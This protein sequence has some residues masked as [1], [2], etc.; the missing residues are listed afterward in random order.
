VR[1]LRA[2]VASLLGVVFV[3]GSALIGSTTATAAEPQAYVAITFTGMS[4]SLPTRSGDVTLEGKVTNTSKVS[5]SNLQAV[6]WRSLD[7]IQD[8]EGMQAALA[9]DAND[10]LGARKADAYQNIP[11]ETDRTLAPK[12]STT[13]KL[14]VRVSALQLPS[15]DAIYLLGIH[16]RGRLEPN[17]PDVTLGRG[18][19]FA[20]I[21]ATAPESAAQLSTLVMLESRPSLIRKGV[22]ADDHLATEIGPDGRLTALLEAA[23]AD[24]S[25]FAVDPAL[26]EELQTMRS[27]YQV[28]QPDGDTVPGT[29]QSAAGRWLADYTRMAARQDGYRLL[30]AHPDVT[31]LVHAGMTSVI[32]G[33]QVA[34]KAVTTT[35]AL[36]LLAVPVSGLLDQATAESLAELDPK[37]I[38]VD[39]AS[40]EQDLPLLKGP[41]GIPLLNT[42]ARTFGGGPGPDPQNTAVQIR[43]RTL[44]ETWLEASAA[45]PDDTIGQLRVIRTKAQ[46][47]SNSD[48][49]EAPW[50]RREPV[51]RLL[52]ST[53][54]AWPGRYRYAESAAKKELS[55]DQIG[56][57]RQLMTSYQTL[58]DL[59]IRPSD[60]ELD[61]D[62]AGARSAS[63]SWRD[64]DSAWMSFVDPQQDALDDIQHNAVKIVA[65]PKVTTTAHSVQFPVT[66]RNTLPATKDDPQ[67]NAIKVRLEFVSANGQRLTVAPTPEMLKQNMQIPAQAGVTSNAQVDAKANGTVRVILRAYTLDGG[68]PIGAPFPIDVQA[69][70]AGTIGWLIAIAAGIVLIGGSALRIRQVTRERAAG[71]DA[72]VAETGSPAADGEAPAADPEPEG[73]ATHPAQVVPPPS[74]TDRSTSPR[75]PE[76]LDV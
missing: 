67:R 46:A 76:S 35:S 69:T 44:A 34:S 16:I 61:A 17:G 26:I 38:V 40:T 22:F 63:S 41:K 37:A 74:E 50:L 29:G 23:G 1:A 48:E 5:L 9:S 18:R 64:R 56:S 75:N 59:L 47:G 54:A 36:P 68:A 45:G 24:K 13:F 49:V 52:Q 15:I 11:S 43:Q 20:P 65:T 53:P 4:P 10:P 39:D 62:A 32:D 66:V 58:G 60:I 14:K 25:S 57:V 3:L 2:L 51:S 12:Q 19:V 72:A 27:G 21:I 73:G 8:S 42:A 71:S 30:F 7:P 28:L 6:F 70:Q 31:A 55:P 33:G